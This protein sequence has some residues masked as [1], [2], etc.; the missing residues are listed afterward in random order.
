METKNKTWFGN[1][2][3]SVIV[4]IIAAILAIIFINLLP[5]EKIF[6]SVL[7][8]VIV[9]HALILLITV[10][11]GWMLLPEKILIKFRK[12]ASADS[13]DFGWSSKWSKGF[14]FA[15]FIVAL[16]AFYSYFGLEGK[17]VLQILVFTVLL[18]LSVN[19][20]IG[21]IIAR[22]S[23]STYDVILPY[24][25]LYKTGKNNVLDA[26]CGAGRTTISLAK[27]SSEVSIVA[28]DRFDANYIDDGGKALLRKNLDLAG[29]SSRVT[30][31]QGDITSMPFDINSFDASVSS[32]MFDHLGKNKL[33]AFKEMYRVLR[34]G[35]RFL[36][37]IAV[38][39]YSSFAIANVLSL[40]FASRNN[41]KSLFKESGFNLIDEGNINFGAFFLIE[42][43]LEQTAV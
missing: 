35:G 23:N 27:T 3:H 2:S 34:P 39:G 12:Q 1:H 28:F 43:P 6:P 40:V 36:L 30:I 21:N 42:K 22:R 41:W 38:R 11:G 19:F 20:F 14:G 32:F 33:Q 29:I 31:E 4:I 15:S 24:V 18:L 37:I 26:G 13:F 17:P 8:G 5:D 25:D 16:L 7:I 9:S 10:F